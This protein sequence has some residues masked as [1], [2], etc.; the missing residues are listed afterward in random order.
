[1][2]RRHGQ[3]KQEAY[4]KL[5][6]KQ[7]EERDDCCRFQEGENDQF[8]GKLMAVNSGARGIL[9]EGIVWLDPDAEDAKE[10]LAMEQLGNVTPP[11][12]NRDYWG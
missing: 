5:I 6:R 8:R 1:M 10:E 2:R 12:K 4:L 7:E 9:E 11:L 3:E